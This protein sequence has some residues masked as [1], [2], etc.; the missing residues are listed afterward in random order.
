MRFITYFSFFALFI[1]AHAAHP[2]NLV[3]AGIH[4]FSSQ[5][6]EVTVINGHIWKIDSLP[7]VVCQVNTPCY[8]IEIEGSFKVG[9]GDVKQGKVG[10][11]GQQLGGQPLWIYAGSKVKLDSPNR[12][13]TVQEFIES[14]ASIKPALPVALTYRKSQ[15][16]VGYVTQ[17]M[18]TSGQPLS[19]LIQVEN[20]HLH[21]GKMVFRLDLPPGGQRE[22]GHLEGWTFY[23]GDEIKI[24]NDGFSP[25]VTRLLI[26]N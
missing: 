10:L 1:F 21:K 24:I 14:F 3:S 22:L 18:N 15:L 7:F 13:V 2:E 4:T 8:A 20:E 16:G 17:F 6:G 26:P 12:F 5:D 9:D 25:L 11:L 19:I 23:S